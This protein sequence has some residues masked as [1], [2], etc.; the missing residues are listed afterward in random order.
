MKKLIIVLLILFLFTLP[1][2]AEQNFAEKVVDEYKKQLPIGK[3]VNYTAETDSNDLLGR[4][5][6]YIDKLSWEDTRIEQSEDNLK[7]GTIELFDSKEDLEKRAKYLEQFVETPMFA[8][9]M[10]V[11]DMVIVRIDKELTPDQAKEYNKILEN[12]D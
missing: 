12:I 9:Y 7:G 4:P 5:R 3:V 2:A 10:Y 6:Q 1:V 11:H 8:Q